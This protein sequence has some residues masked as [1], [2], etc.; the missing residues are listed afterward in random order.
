MYT[1]SRCYTW[2]SV[3]QEVRRGGLAPGIVG[4]VCSEPQS[5]YFVRYKERQYITVLL[6]HVSHIVIEV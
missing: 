5:I 2:Y 4:E 6:G 1:Y 3:V